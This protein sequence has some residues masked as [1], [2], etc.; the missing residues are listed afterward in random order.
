MRGLVMTP[1]VFLRSNW[2]AQMMGDQV[3]RGGR[4]DPECTPR[5]F[6]PVFR[7]VN[8]KSRSRYVRITYSEQAARIEACLSRIYSKW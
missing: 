6:L 5:V 3:G 7:T 1:R 4:G 2:P 8:L